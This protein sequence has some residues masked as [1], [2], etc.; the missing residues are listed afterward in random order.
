MSFKE[1]VKCPKCGSSVTDT[2]ISSVRVDES[3]WDNMRICFA[4]YHEIIL[5][6]KTD[7]Y[8]PPV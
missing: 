1:S 8:T 3:D 7:Q 6:P 4:C 5:D 2:Y